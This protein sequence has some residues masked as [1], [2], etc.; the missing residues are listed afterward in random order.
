MLILHRVPSN[1]TATLSAEL[2]L[3]EPAVHGLEPMQSLFD[4]WGEPPIRLDLVDERC[5]PAYLGGIEDIEEGCAGRLRFVRDIRVPCNRTVPV[6]EERVQ[7]ALAAVSVHQMDLGVPLRLTG[8]RV[9]MMA[10]KV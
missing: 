1:N 6:R 2:R 4:G 7:L 3:L 10:A 5:V 8:S 9:D